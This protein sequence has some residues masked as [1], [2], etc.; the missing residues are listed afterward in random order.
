MVRGIR[1]DLVLRTF[2]ARQRE[3]ILAQAR[4]RVAT[5]NAPVATET[6][7]TLGLPAFLD[8]LDEALCRACLRESVDHG[9]IAKSASQHGTAL[10]R[11]GLTVAQVVHDYGDLCQVITAL[12][13]EQNAPIA[14]ADFQTLNL[15][16]DD[17]I[18]GAVT[19]YGEQRERSVADAG[20]ER[21]GVLAHEMRNELSTAILT[22]GVIKKGVV[23]TGGATSVMLDRS[24]MRLNVLIDRSLAQ[25]RLDAGRQHLERIPVH[26]VLEEVEIGASIVAQAR[27]LQLKVTT[28]EPSIIVE[29]DRQILT[30]AVANLVQ[31]ALKFTGKGTTVKLRAST[32]ATRVLIDVEDECGGLPEEMHAS[33]LRPFVQGGSDRTGLGLGLHICV[34]AMKT[35]AGELRIRDLPGDGCVFTIDLP[36]QPPPTLTL[37]TQDDNPRDDGE[38][39][40]EGQ[41][42][43]AAHLAPSASARSH[44][45]GRPA[46]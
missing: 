44:V 9:E 15:C 6:E 31:N 25:V 11:N 7:L 14:P 23:A 12:A 24:H 32:T 2:I 30:A 45:A 13:V 34:K 4:N 38:S 39:G 18:A 3:E 5:R 37:L 26:E 28:V 22:F 42:A 1:Y 21:L 19:A 35:M 27:G 46:R 43:R 33:L 29:A 41:T 40:S 17:A 8:Q 36:K 20:T 16:L 10:F